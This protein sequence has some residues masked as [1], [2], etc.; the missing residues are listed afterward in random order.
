MDAHAQAGSGVV[1]GLEQD[2]PSTIA[3]VQVI[4]EGPLPKSFV[5]RVLVCPSNRGKDTVCSERLRLQALDLPAGK[6]L[7]EV[8]LQHWTKKRFGVLSRDVQASNGRSGRDAR[9]VIELGDG[10]RALGEGDVVGLE[11]LPEVVTHESPPLSGLTF[12]LAAER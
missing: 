5:A 2:L 3:L 4:A 9:L 7:R 11:E 1:H 8:L 6:T 10:A 12:A